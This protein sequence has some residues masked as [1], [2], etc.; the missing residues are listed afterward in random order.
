MDKDIYGLVGDPIQHSL[1]PDIHNALFDQHD[2]DAEY[3]LF[4][5]NELTPIIKKLKYGKIKGVNVTKPYKIEI[6][7]HLDELE[8]K[9]K[10]IG[11]SN[12]ISQHDGEI[13]GYNTDGIGAK[14]TL[15]RF[16]EIKNKRI[17]QLS[18]GGAGKAIAYE[19]AKS[20]EVIVL[21]RTLEKAK[22]LERFGVEVK[23]LE[24]E[25]L[26]RELERAD[27]LINATSVGMNE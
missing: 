13:K 12:T 14:E 10:E 9:V 20:S 6:L 26:K 5:V 27:V 17:L 25:T 3:R 2:I 23:E 16:G 1:S 8:E 15:E 18:A 19:L 4:E 7:D 24:Q 21:N 11:S 22:S